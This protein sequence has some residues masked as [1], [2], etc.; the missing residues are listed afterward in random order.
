MAWAQ[1]IG[2]AYF[3]SLSNTLTTA[4]LPAIEV[5][6]A[7]RAENL[8]NK[9][10][11]S[12]GV[13]LN[14][15]SADGSYSFGGS[16]SVNVSSNFQTFT[17]TM[18]DFSIWGGDAAVASFATNYARAA[19]AEVT[20]VAYSPNGDFVNDPNCIFVVDDVKV[21]QRT[22]PPL[23]VSTDGVHAYF[24]WTDHT[25]VLLSA[26]SPTGPWTPISI[27]LIID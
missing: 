21:V 1:V 17:L 8:N 15:K 25:L 24:T 16:Q 3:G 13:T 12:F 14:L 9:T 27:N 19:I 10:N 5:S 20:A 23:S 26:T 11:T 6:M 18:N 7:L 22:S 2:E 4:Y